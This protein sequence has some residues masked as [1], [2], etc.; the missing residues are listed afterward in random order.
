VETRGGM[1]SGN[2]GRDGSAMAEAGA[3]NF[4]VHVDSFK[5]TSDDYSIP[6]GKQLNTGENSE[7]YSLGG[8]YVF[9]K[10]YIGLAY[11][12]FDST[13]FIPGGEQATDKNHI[14]LT[15]SK[16]TSRG[17]WRV[18]DMGIDAVRFWFGATD[19]K[20]N[21]VDGLDASAVIGSRPSSTRSMKRALK[22][23]SSRSRRR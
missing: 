6:G 9:N 4:A 7:G 15:Q 11:T 13:Y 19:Y 14:V 22:L 10:G 23:N 20:H 8:S 17:E 2:N 12:S 16:W 21:E 1:T 18:N 5:R 3:G